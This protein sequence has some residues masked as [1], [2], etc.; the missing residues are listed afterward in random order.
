MT[1][2]RNLTII[3]VVVSVAAFIL[4]PIIWPVVEGAEQPTA[5]QLPFLI[6][7][8]VIEALS[9]GVAVAFLLFARPFVKSIADPTARKSGYWTLWSIAWLI[10]SWWVHDNLHRVNGDNL[11]GLIYI[12]Y[13]FHVTLIVA[14]MLVARFFISSLFSTKRS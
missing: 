10:G 9:L 5:G 13:A 2:K 6:L 7:L 1:S 11:Q 3:T 8:S 4:G 14:A 12:E